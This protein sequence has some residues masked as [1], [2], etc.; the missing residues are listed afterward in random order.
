MF[1]RLAN[2]NGKTRLQYFSTDENSAEKKMHKIQIKF[3][4]FATL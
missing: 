1:D 4:K 3:T 2:K